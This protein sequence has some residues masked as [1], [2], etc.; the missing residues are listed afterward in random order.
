MNSSMIY[1]NNSMILMPN[2]K[3][4]SS[5]KID[6]SMKAIG[7]MERET[8]KGNKSG[9]MAPSMKDI[10]KTILPTALAD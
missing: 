7:K 1:S 2:T 6:T 3:A 8:G 10:G 5:L 9:R 4:L